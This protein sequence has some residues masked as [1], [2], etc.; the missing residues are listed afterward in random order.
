MPEAKSIMR[1]RITPWVP[2]VLKWKDHDGT[3]QVQSFKLSYDMNA[4]GLVEQQLGISMLTDAGTI[5][6]T[7]TA[8]NVSVLL[9]AAV[10]E[11]QPE[12][13]GEAGLRAIRSLLTV[14]TVKTAVIACSEAYITQLTDEKQKLIREFQEAKK[15]GSEAP[16]PLAESPATSE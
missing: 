12:Y 6:D 7:P 9:W 2:F 13:E 10:Q 1:Q 4:F 15:R 8:K 11:N 3:E 5:F 14:A 16:S